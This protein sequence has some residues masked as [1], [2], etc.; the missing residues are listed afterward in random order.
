M[1]ENAKW[2]MAG[3]DGAGTLASTDIRRSRLYLMD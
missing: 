1:K 3:A 2:T